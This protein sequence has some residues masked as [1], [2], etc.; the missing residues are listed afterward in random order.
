MIVVLAV[1]WL[2]LTVV[3]PMIQLLPSVRA[4]E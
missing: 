4:F 1:N 2:C 3:L